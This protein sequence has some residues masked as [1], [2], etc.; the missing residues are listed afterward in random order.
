MGEG[1]GRGWFRGWFKFK[2]RLRLKGPSG[3]KSFVEMPRC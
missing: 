3:A 2:L 1:W